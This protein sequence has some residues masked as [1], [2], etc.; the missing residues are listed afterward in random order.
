[1]TAKPSG[2]SSKQQANEP[3]LS[4]QLEGQELA[5]IVAR[6]VKVKNDYRASKTPVPLMVMS[7]PGATAPTRL[8]RWQAAATWTIWEAAMLLHGFDPGPI[9]SAARTQ[10]SLL[11]RPNQA[12]T[13]EPKQKAVG[14]CGQ[15]FIG[16]RHFWPVLEVVDAWRRE[17]DATEKVSPARFIKWCKQRGLD[18]GWLR[19]IKEDEFPTLA[20]VDAPIASGAGSRAHDVS[21]PRGADGVLTL[22]EIVDEVGALSGASPQ[23]AWA[24][25]REALWQR[26]QKAAEDGH[27]R[28]RHPDTLLSEIFKDWPSPSSA[29]LVC[30]V[31][32]IN[33]WLE[34]DGSPYRLPAPSAGAHPVFRGAGAVLPHHSDLD[35]SLLATRQQLIA[36]FGAFTG[37]DQGWFKNLT[38]TPGLLSARKIKGSGG[39]GHL[40]EPLFCPFDVMRWLVS[41]TRKKG[42]KLGEDKA[43]ELLEK[44]FP[45]AYG[46]HS[47]ADSRET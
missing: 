34:V 22:L 23:N 1:M 47:A 29:A 41:D 2:D 37:M 43:W 39:R 40:Q 46:A 12:G 27:L 4:R 42:R 15:W 45:K 9:G 5:D 44:H 35:L 13:I 16:E 7:T 24:I 31:S 8:D 19:T 6:D 38:D 21:V 20:E 28:V 32:D 30:T 36:A 33:A 17:P 11:G 26:V 3:S 18:T 14:L 10:E 25:Q